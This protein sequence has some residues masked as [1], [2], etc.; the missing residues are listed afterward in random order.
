[1]RHR[2]AAINGGQTD[3]SGVTFIY[4][5][6]RGL[7]PRR[8]RS[9]SRIRKKDPQPVKIPRT[10]QKGANVLR[11]KKTGLVGKITSISLGGRALYQGGPGPVGSASKK[12]G[13]LKR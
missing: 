10:F 12:G 9:R 13:V 2:K 11:M 1:M 7:L 4:E 6:P 3:T 5:D 8:G